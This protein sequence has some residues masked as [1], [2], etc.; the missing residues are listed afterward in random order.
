MENGLPLLLQASFFGGWL[1]LATLLLRRVR[2]R[3]AALCCALAALLR[4]LLPLPLESPL[5]LH[6]LWMDPRPQMVTAVQLS[7][8][9]VAAISGPA[10]LAAG[11]PAFLLPLWAAGMAGTLT[12]FALRFFKQRRLLRL[13]IPVPAAS[14]LAQAVKSPG[15]GRGIAVY[16]CENV[17]APLAAGVFRPRILLPSGAEPTETMLLALM[18]E[19]EHIRRRHNLLKALMLLACCLH[20]FNP[21][22]W[23]LQRALCEEL[24]LCCDRHALE[25]LGQ[26]ARAPYARALLHFYAREPACAFSSGFGGG[27]AEER[28]RQIMHY[29]PPRRGAAA[30]SAGAALLLFFA[31]ASLPAV[32]A[33]SVTMNTAVETFSDGWVQ[34]EEGTLSLWD[35]AI[36]DDEAEQPVTEDVP[37]YGT[38]MVQQAQEGTDSV[39]LRFSLPFPASASRAYDVQT[40]AAGEQGED[41]AGEATEAG[42]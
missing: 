10:G 6:R 33:V 32:T 20:W 42:F 11:L 12:V 27:A 24:E 36:A 3:C 18:H 34:A 38:Y 9:R 21:L 2:A 7:D 29:R 37:Y 17:L 14:P 22:C 35:G 8:G 41:A 16:T 15:K 30:L 5:S 28:I 40:A 31:L 26:D 13:C 23:R 4:L 1:V 39:L 25:R 19:A